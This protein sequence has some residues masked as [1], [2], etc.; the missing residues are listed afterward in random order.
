[1]TSFL[2]RAAAAL[3]VAGLGLGGAAHAQQLP[4][5][6]T[7]GQI[8]RQFQTLPEPRATDEPVVSPGLEPE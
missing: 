5:S 1:V 4:G 2:G 3:V 6:V 8:E 7:P